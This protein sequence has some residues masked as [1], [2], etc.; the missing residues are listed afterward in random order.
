LTREAAVPTVAIRRLSAADREAALAVVNEA[1]R[2]YREFLP[3]G[4]YHEPEM[5]AGDWDQEVP[6][7]PTRVWR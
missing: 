3:P 6:Y 4:E 5:T 2:W 1:A 7:R